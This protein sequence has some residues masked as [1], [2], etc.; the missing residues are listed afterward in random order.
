MCSIGDT[1][2]G[3]SGTLEAFVPWCGS[4]EMGLADTANPHSARTP[5]A[6]FWRRTLSQIP[7]LFGRLAYLASLRDPLT[8][9]Y[10]QETLIRMLGAEQADRTLCQSHYQT[11][12][13]WLC[14]SLMEQKNDLGEYLNSAQLPRFAMHYRHLVPRTAREV[15]RQ[16][17]LTDLE[18]LLQLLQVERELASAS[19][20]T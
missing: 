14:F 18:T 15:E 5:A 10:S 12:S 20:T 3:G 17:Y 6:E 2:A 13:Q 9:R 4:V 8:G 19:S 16:L 1:P 11:F 7:T